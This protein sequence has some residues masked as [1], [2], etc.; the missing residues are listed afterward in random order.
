MQQSRWLFQGNRNWFLRNAHVFSMQT[1]V[2]MPL[3]TSSLKNM[4][5]LLITIPWFSY[6]L[7]N[8]AQIARK[9]PASFI[10]LF[11][12]QGMFREICI[13]TD[14]AVELAFPFSLTNRT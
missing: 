11:I 2:C 14:N 6:H 7:L 13:L 9:M 5:D 12:N 10:V 4:T 8:T 1:C 3:R